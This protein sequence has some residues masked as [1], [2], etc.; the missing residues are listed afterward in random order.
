MAQGCRQGCGCE[1][2]A[3]AGFRA[4]EKDDPASAATYCLTFQGPCQ[5]PKCGLGPGWLGLEELRQC[6]FRGATC[7][8]GET[9]KNWSL[10]RCGSR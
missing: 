9:G 1:R 10:G 5:L 7:D 6:G 4:G 8:V 2:L 3:L